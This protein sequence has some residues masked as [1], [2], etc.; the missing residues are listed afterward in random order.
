M[1][2]LRLGQQLEELKDRKHRAVIVH[3]GVVC[4]LLG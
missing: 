1:E 2:I 4:D 3:M